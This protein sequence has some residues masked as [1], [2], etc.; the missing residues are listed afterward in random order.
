MAG[1][2][3]RVPHDYS[4]RPLTPLSELDYENVGEYEGGTTLAQMKDGRWAVELGIDEY[5]LS[6]DDGNP[7]WDHPVA[8]ADIL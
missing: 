4:G 6:D 5:Y 7:L 2:G 1:K 3:E 8:S